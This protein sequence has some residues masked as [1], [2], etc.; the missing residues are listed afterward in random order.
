MRQTIALHFLIISLLFPIE[1]VTAAPADGWTK[2]FKFQTKMANNGSVNAQYIIGEMYEEGRG[3]D[4]NNDKAF[5]WYYKAKKNGHEDAANR[6]LLLEN[7]IASEK[8]KKQQRAK[9]AKAAKVSK[10]KRKVPI[11]VKKKLGSVKPKKRQKSI[12]PK[13]KII[14]PKLEKKIASPDDFSRGEGTH[15]DV[16]DA[17]E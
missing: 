5:E 16:D 7:K 13:T 6:I 2:I 1:V 17:F 10:S 15:M 14:Q 3:V 11:R 9:K 12:A 8:L 4:Q